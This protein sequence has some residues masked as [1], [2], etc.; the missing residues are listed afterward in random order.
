MPDTGK[1]PARSW[2]HLNQ[3]TKEGREMNSLL[4]T[5]KER[6][7]D[8]RRKSESDRDTLLDFLRKK[9]AEL[10]VKADRQRLLSL[11]RKEVSE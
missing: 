10:E 7:P 2:S 3:G 4:E 9:N 8:K 1:C 6:T 5:L 11:A